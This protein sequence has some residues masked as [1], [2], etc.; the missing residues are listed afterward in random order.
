M[1]V[2]LTLA[3]FITPLS[4]SRKHFCVVYDQRDNSADAL[5][6]AKYLLLKHY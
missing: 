1:G 6:S 3:Y 4:L 5:L 2:L